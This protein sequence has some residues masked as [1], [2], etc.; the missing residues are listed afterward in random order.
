MR[1]AVI[2]S[3][4]SRAETSGE[5]L[6]V[7]LQVEVLRKFGYQVKLISAETDENFGISDTYLKPAFAVATGFGRNPLGDLEE[8]QPDVTI[9]HN[10]HPNFGTHWM[11]KW[12][13]PI[14]RV[15]HNFR[16]F[17]ASGTF[18]RDGNLCLECVDSNPLKGL[19]HAC[20][21]S[22]RI[23]TAP[24]TIAQIHRKLNPI[25]LNT[26]D[27]YLA[28]SDSQKSILVNAGMADSQIKVVPNFVRD[29]FKDMHKNSHD[30]NGKWVAVG[31]L[32][33]EKGFVEL[34]SSWPDEFELDL[35]G[36]GPL[37]REISEIIKTKPRIRMLGKVTQTELFEKLPSYF[38]AILPSLCFEVAPLTALEFLSAG[39]PIVT[40]KI[41]S[42]ALHVK[43]TKAGVIIENIS[44][45]ELT[46]ALN[47][48]IEKQFQMSKNARFAYQH[49]YTP[50]VWEKRIAQLFAS[51]TPNMH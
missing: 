7:D 30:S 1:I 8:F 38:G 19:I 3:Y 22:S 39:L 40:T 28:L 2:H 23:S 32:S 11:S 15:L 4:Y 50:E 41:N 44:K 33:P 18:F 31:R 47:E 16:L 49:D 45:E 5:N 27:V 14:V 46:N 43:N 25:K 24:L 9:V 20:Y 35:I 21:R 51:L 10:L 42:M 12:D 13:G 26:P 36:D 37:S 34:V 17:C 6:V 48:V 29:H